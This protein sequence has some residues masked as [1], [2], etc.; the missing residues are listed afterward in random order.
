MTPLLLSEELFLLTHDDASGKASSALAVNQGLAG[1]LLLDLA[2]TELLDTDDDDDLVAAKAAGAA[3]HPLLIEAHRVIAE[4]DRHRSAKHWVNKLPGELKPLGQRVGTSLAE[5]GILEEQRR[6]VLGLFPSTTWPEVDPA[7]ERELRARL[8]D[9]LV[10]GVEPE[11]RTAMLIALLSPLGLVKG[12][13][14]KTE[15]K[16]AEARAKAIAESDVGSAATSAAVKSA[17]QAIQAAIIFSAIIPATTITS[18]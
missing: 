4:S 12:V 1:G 14:E 2:A 17:V 5:R 16:D 8:H 3:D 13:V 11:P 6:K 7:P 15:R 18:T 9:V 10:K